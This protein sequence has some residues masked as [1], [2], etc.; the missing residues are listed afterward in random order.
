MSHNSIDKTVYL[1]IDLSLRLQKRAATMSCSVE[2][3]T[4]MALTKYLDDKEFDDRIDE[5]VAAHGDKHITAL[6]NSDSDIA[7]GDDDHT[8]TLN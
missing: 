2:E 4:V 3:L 5:M 1:G 7:D 6:T 8:P